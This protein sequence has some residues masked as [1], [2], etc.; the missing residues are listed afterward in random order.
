MASLRS[1]TESILNV[2]IWLEDATDKELCID[3]DSG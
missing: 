1:R 2:V 3:V